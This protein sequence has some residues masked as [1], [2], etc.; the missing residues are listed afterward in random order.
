[1]HMGFQSLKARVRGRTSLT[2]DLAHSSPAASIRSFLFIG[3]Y[4]SLYHP[5]IHSNSVKHS[6]KFAKNLQNFTNFCIMIGKRLIYTWQIFEKYR[7]FISMLSIEAK[8]KNF[9]QTMKFWD[10]IN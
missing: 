8:S 2:E 7:I 9:F 3:M 1:M 4:Q 6:A 10:F 5:S